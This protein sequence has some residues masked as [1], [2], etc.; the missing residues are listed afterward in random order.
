MNCAKCG[1]PL[2]DGATFCAV[3]GAPTDDGASPSAPPEPSRY[4]PKFDVPPSAPAYGRAL[5]SG[6]P[7]AAG[8]ASGR[9]IAR[10]KAILFSPKREWIV[11]AGENPPPAHVHLRYVA[12]LAAIGAIAS[13]VGSAFVGIP[14]PLHGMVR[15]SLPAAFAGALLHLAMTF[16]TVFVVATIVDALAPT[17]GGQKGARRALQVTAYSFTPAWVASVL[18]IF[19]ALAP[20]AGLL[21]LYGL[22]LLYLGLPLLMRA[23]PDKALGYTVVIVLCTVAVSVAISIASGLV[24]SALLPDTP[25][26][27]PGSGAA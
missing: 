9:L 23:A 25:V 15:L 8:T 19:P 17:F 22:Y 11:I 24:L 3:C 14:V 6:P 10:I 2:P 16:I 4:G 27:P 21:G 5:G 13:L 18:T 12:P 1:K 20:L 7:P 26:R